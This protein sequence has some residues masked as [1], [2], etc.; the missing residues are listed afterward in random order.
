M[1]SPDGEVMRI[2]CARP[3]RVKKEPE[4]PLAK[5]ARFADPPLP[6]Q[7]SPSP[8]KPADPQV[9]EPELPSDDDSADLAL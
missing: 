2:R 7:V 5:R 6:P 9:A 4:V 1:L 8:E 3:D